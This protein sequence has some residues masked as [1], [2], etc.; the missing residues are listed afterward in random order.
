MKN[1]PS[2]IIVPHITVGFIVFGVMILTAIW[3]LIYAWWRLRARLVKE[4]LSLWRRVLAT[5]GLLAVSVQALL[6][7]LY[8]TRVGPSDALLG[9]WS[10]W[11]DL[12]FFVAAPCVLAEKGAPRWWLLSSSILLF[13]MCFFISLS[14]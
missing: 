10:R 2:A 1:F 3:G 4:P 9:Q 5:I 14:P 12:A 13:T 7:I 11:V 6:F 8:W